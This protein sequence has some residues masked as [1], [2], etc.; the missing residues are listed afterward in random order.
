MHTPSP[1]LYKQKRKQ[2][3][4]IH[5][6]TFI[7]NSYPP[8]LENK[9]TTVLLSLILT[10]STTIISWG[11]LNIEPAVAD[12][13][14]EGGRHDEAWQTAAVRGNCLLFCCLHTAKASKVLALLVQKQPN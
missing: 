3:N 1:L 4:I 9:R 7:E 11:Q 14:I 10:G 8:S 12:C 13:I 2:I 5:L 6:I